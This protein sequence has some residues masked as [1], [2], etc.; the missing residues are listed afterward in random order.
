MRHPPARRLLPTL[1]LVVLGAF[2]LRDFARLG[3]ALPWRNMDDFPDFYCA[4]DALNQGGNPYTYEP[5]RTC[6]HRVNTGDG[7]RARLFASNPSVAVPAPL[8]P[9]DL[10]PLRALARLPF[11][12][13]RFFDALAIVAAIGLCVAALAAMGIP[14]P[15]SAAALAL[16]ALYVELNAGQIVPFAL[17]ALVLCGLALSRRRDAL[18]GVFAAFAVISPTAGLPAVA[19][20]LLFVPRARWAALATL[21]AFAAISVA[22]VG[23]HVLGTYVAGV[24]P[25]QA[26]AE[27]HFP[28]QFSLTYALAY[29]GVPARA[30]EFA[31]TASYFVMLGAGLLLSPRAAAAT[32]R[33]E[34]FAFLPVLFTTIAATY[35]HQEE[36]A[37][38]IP[39]L[40]VLAVGADGIA[41]IALAV[42]LSLLSIPWILVWG[43]KQLFAASIVSCAVI[44]FQLRVGLKPALGA[45]CAIA[46][47]VYLFELHPPYV[48]APG[49]TSHIYASDALVQEEWRWYAMQRT[50]R[51]PLWFAIKLP[52]WS[53]LLAGFGIAF[54]FRRK[55]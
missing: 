30:A 39:A 24:L 51:D 29:I 48:P 55:V 40:L 44:L 16:S 34:L 35:V 28:Y 33:R 4:G 18:A 19:A 14:W 22:M 37:F 31:G 36:L 12:E 20:M 45:L 52:A 9:F 42:S 38:A 8:P 47:V 5:L 54:T 49:P 2:A 17:L 32:Q 43:S 50:S 7:F 41:R 23:M 11:E 26:A 10:L 3:E 15:L 21:L 1:L 27:V 46:L 6:E 13:A 53:A 25:A